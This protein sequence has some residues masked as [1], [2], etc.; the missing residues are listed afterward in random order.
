M[1]QNVSRDR[2]RHAAR[3]I[4]LLHPEGCPESLHRSGPHSRNGEGKGETRKAP[5]TLPLGGL[6]AYS[7]LAASCGQA[8][9][10][11]NSRAICSSVNE[12]ISPVGDTAD[13]ART[14]VPRIQS[15]R[16]AT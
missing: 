8:S 4:E 13:D 15:S 12:T 3:A 2:L 7:I 6:T 16:W 11:G 10:S 5:L 14:N 1:G 9:T